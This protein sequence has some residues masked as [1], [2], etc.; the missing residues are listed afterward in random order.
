MTSPTIAPAVPHPTAPSPASTPAKV[1]KT[2]VIPVPKLF[3]VDHGAVFSELTEYSMDELT[4][5]TPHIATYAA[6]L[7]FLSRCLF[8]VTF[9]IL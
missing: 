1:K 4:Y 3:K 7:R 8:L 6:D 5:K 2:R 9:I